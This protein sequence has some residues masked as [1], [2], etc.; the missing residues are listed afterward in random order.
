MLAHAVQQR[1]PA[2]LKAV[3]NRLKLRHLLT[4][5]KVW[6]R[7]LNSILKGDDPWS[8]LTHVANTAGTVPLGFMSRTFLISWAKLKKQLGG[9]KF[10][11]GNGRFGVVGP[12]D[13]PFLS[14][15]FA[16]KDRTRLVLV[17]LAARSPQEARA[18][19]AKLATLQTAT[20]GGPPLAKSMRSA[21][22]H[23]VEV[24]REVA[25]DVADGIGVQLATQE[26]NKP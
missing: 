20:L 22:N 7:S 23:S 18:V 14:R 10:S 4:P 15:I 25:S 13:E 1:R 21:M 12:S 26:P 3:H 19:F 11:N 24:W 6:R 5:A 17:D 9:G 16:T 2:R 8:P